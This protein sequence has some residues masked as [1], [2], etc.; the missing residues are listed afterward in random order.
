MFILLPNDVGSHS[1]ILENKGDIRQLHSH[2]DLQ[3]SSTGR[4]NSHRKWGG[5]HDYLRKT[6]YLYWYQ[7]FRVILKVNIQKLTSKIDNISRWV[8]VHRSYH[9]T[10][11][12]S[13]SLFQVKSNYSI[14]FFHQTIGANKEDLLNKIL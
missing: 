8:E 13:R 10:S 9:R 7:T 11:I 1:I 6:N 5:E 12:D 2:S 14:N 4:A 3:L